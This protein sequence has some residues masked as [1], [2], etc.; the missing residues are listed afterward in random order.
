MMVVNICGKRWGFDKDML[1]RAFVLKNYGLQY[2]PIKYSIIIVQNG[3]PR[4]ATLDLLK[5]FFPCNLAIGG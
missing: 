2:Q 5:N 3:R 4:T 1:S